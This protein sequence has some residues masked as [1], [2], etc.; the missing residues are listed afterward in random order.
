MVLRIESGS[1]EFWELVA[2]IMKAAESG[3]AGSIPS[4]NNGL[5]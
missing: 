3:V 1:P 4:H 5:M 2:S